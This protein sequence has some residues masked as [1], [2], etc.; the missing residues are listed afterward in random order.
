MSERKNDLAG[1]ELSRRQ[2]LGGTAV[3]SSF[4]IVPRHVLG[5]PGYQAPSDKLNIACIGIGGKGFSDS[6]KMQGENVIAL[7]DVDEEKLTEKHGEQDQEKKSPADLFPKAKFYKDFRVM[8]EKEKEIDAVTV[9]TPDHT[10]AVAAMMA[11]KMKK[12]VFVQKPLTHTIKEARVL[13]ATAKE[14][15]VVTQ[16]GNQGHAQEGGRLICEWIWAG[17]IGEI[18]E[19]HC[20][21]NRP[22]WPQG[23]EAPKETPSCPPTLDWDLWLGPA[24][25]RPYHPA[26]APFAWRGFWDFGTG[27]IGD[28][29][30]HI[31][32]H[33]YWPLKLK[34]PSKIY[35]S[36]TKFT[37]ASAPEAEVLVYDFPA[38]GKMPPVRVYW[39]D[40]GLVPPRP[41]D[42][43]PGRRMGDGG[44][45]VLFIGSKGSIMGGTYGENPRLIPE[46]KMKEFKRP[47][48]T[49]PRSPGIHE[50]WIAAC[51]KGDPKAATTNFEYSGPLTETM[52]LGNVAVR[53]KEKNM[54]FDWDGDKG[55]ITNCPEANALLHFEYR[56]GWTL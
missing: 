16:M 44:G 31:I 1:K 6:E 55:E 37:E 51:K 10:H 21:T 5:G 8:L 18:R 48:K 2:F 32:D 41:A 53:M 46:T 42:L 27:A 45:G 33:V 12:H 17:A 54:V 26:Y 7:C 24:A 3:A 39:W 20:W 4:I 15:G 30:A 28:M 49:I 40:G 11:M 43:E 52:L 29:G 36:S 14:M 19:A 56:K 13:T 35:A 47:E 23:I 25:W 50:E 34:Y 22:I 9:S 38:R